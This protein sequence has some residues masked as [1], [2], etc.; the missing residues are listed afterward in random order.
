MQRV[1]AR[2]QKNTAVR[3]TSARHVSTGDLL[4][5]AVDVIAWVHGH[6]LGLGI[7]GALHTAHEEGEGIEAGDLIGLIVRFGQAE[8]GVAAF[9]QSRAFQV[10]DIIHRGDL[11][12][13]VEEEAPSYWN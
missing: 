1:L 10:E 9:Q 13:E 12:D 11:A 6:R 4:F 3:R 5:L 7:K 2:R 8:I